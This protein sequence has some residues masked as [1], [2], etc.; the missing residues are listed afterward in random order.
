MQWFKI[1]KLEYLEKGTEHSQKLRGVLWHFDWATDKW[2]L[3]SDY[4]GYKN[5]LNVAKMLDY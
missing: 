1:E 2:R 4:V 3:K 5:K